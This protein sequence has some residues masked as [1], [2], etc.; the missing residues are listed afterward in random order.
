MGYWEV[1]GT[2]ELVGDKQSLGCA[3]GGPIF[4]LFLSLPLLPGHDELNSLAL[5][6]VPH[7]GV[8][9]P[10]DHGP[11]PLESWAKINFSFFKLTFL[12]ILAQQW[13]ADQHMY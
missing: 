13:K 12:G 9:E 10:S 2:L 7:H 6:R 8:L 4:S 3:L 1:V 11:K 5:P